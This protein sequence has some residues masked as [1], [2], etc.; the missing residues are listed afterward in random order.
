MGLLALLGQVGDLGSLDTCRALGDPHRN[1]VRVGLVRLIAV[2]RQ[3]RGVRG[4]KHVVIQVQG[5]VFQRSHIKRFDVVGGAD[6]P[7]FLRAPERESHRVLHIGARPQLQ[8][9]LQ[10][11]GG[12]GAVVVDPR[13]LR[14]TVQMR[15]GHD[16]ICRGARL[17]LR[18]HV[19]RLDVLGLRIDVEDNL[20]RMGPQVRTDRFRN[21]HHRDLG[22]GVLTKGAARLILVD[23]VRDDHGGGAALGGN[24]F[25]VGEWA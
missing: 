24:P 10:H 3:V 11:R 18:D 9:R 19:A 12:A 4:T 6:Q 2:V 25:L 8:R 17:G 16:D 15:T 20:V 14:N 7:F 5:N 22:A 1:L 21:A 23:V 13:P